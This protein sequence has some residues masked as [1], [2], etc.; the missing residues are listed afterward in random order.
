M[1]RV[2]RGTKGTNVHINLAGKIAIGAG[3]AVGTALL[4]SACGK[5]ED[6]QAKVLKDFQPFDTDRN[7]E[8]S[9]D[10]LVRRTETRP[11][12]VTV[13]RLRISDDYVQVTQNIQ[14]DITTS[15]MSRAY[16]GARG[17]DAIAS[18]AE[19]TSLALSFD[20]ADKNG[21]KNGLLDGSERRAFEAAYGVQTNRQ[22]I[23]DNTVT[24]LE[25]SP[26]DNYP[27]NP[28]GG[29]SHGDDGGVGNGGNHGG[30]SGGD[31]GGVGNGGNN[32]GTSGGDDG[33]VSNPP[34]SNGGNSGGTSGGDS[35]DNG[36]PSD[37]DF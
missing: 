31:D 26:R 8:W 16:A 20:Q 12:P 29:T 36:N 28:G 4:L 18:L 11:Y 14:H 1:V 21:V 24:R 19:L 6:P 22:T 25:Y 30:T 33:G 27:N 2:R 32:G 37:D 9:K 7:N 10:E 23:V 5:D 34:P 35:T 15:N 17:N 13:G 3:L